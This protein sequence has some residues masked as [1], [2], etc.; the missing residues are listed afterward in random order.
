ML[1]MGIVEQTSGER[2]FKEH[3][4][5]RCRALGFQFSTAGGTVSTCELER[6]RTR[7]RS[8]VQQSR[9]TNHQF[10][11]YGWITVSSCGNFA[12]RHHFSSW[13]SSVISIPGITMNLH[14]SISR[15]S[16]SSGNWQVTRQYW[17]S[18]FQQNRPYGIVSGLM[19]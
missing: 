12:R 11:A 2:N 18:W 9:A 1:H 13:L 4:A 15:E 16:S 17:Q 6:H 3:K 14:A 10:T 7:R 5:T 19:N 8:G